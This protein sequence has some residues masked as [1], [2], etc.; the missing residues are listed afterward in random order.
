MEVA[1]LLATLERRVRWVSEGRYA[2]EL[3]EAMKGKLIIAA[4]VDGIVRDE[5]GR[6]LITRRS[7]DGEWDLPGG[8]VEPG[9]T[10]AE[11]LTR[12]VREETGLVVRVVRVAGVFGGKTFRHRY[13]DGQEIE[14]FSVT[15]ECE[16]TGGKLR[17]A[18]GE[19]TEFKFVA[20]PELPELAWPYPREMFLTR[21][22]VY[23]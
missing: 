13:P 16:I 9:E 8:S 7:D 2:K 5:D 14:A 15:F 6:I 11:A 3:K 19:A 1:L 17:S 10:P 23:V 20:A 12:E 21:Q 4:G 18:D 22:V